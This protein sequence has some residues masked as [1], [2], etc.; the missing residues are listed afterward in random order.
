MAV[1]PYLNFEGR[2][3]EAIELYKRAIGAD[4]VMLMHFR[5]APPADRSHM[6]PGTENMVMHAALTIA[7]STVLASDGYCTGKADFSGISLAL[8]LPTA[9]AAE[10]TFAALADGGTVLQP[11]AEAFFSAR[12]GIVADRFGVPWMI[13]VTAA[14][15]AA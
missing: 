2:C 8:D 3:E 4:V 15:P 5:D 13:T 1:Q 6:T 12:F 7:G 10:S 9:D 11:L 14:P